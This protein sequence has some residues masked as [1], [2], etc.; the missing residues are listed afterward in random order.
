M[1]GAFTRPD[2]AHVCEGLRDTARLQR[3]NKWLVLCMSWGPQLLDRYAIM[4]MRATAR[5]LVCGWWGMDVSGLAHGIWPLS[6]I[7]K[8]PEI[9]GRRCGCTHRSCIKQSNNYVDLCWEYWRRGTS[10]INE[11]DTEVLDWG[12]DRVLRTCL[13]TSL[14]SIKL[15]RIAW[16]LGLT[17]VASTSAR[18]L[19]SWA[20]QALS[21]HVQDTIVFD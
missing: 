2:K 18:G 9:C 19:D 10:L 12:K 21:L 14:A 17:Q 16:P 1:K 5:A 8:V 4:W 3:T 20:K 13:T 7:A 6:W 11:G 15:V